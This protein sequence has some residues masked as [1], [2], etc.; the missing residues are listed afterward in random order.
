MAQTKPVKGDVRKN[1]QAHIDLVE[2]AINHEVE[3]IVFPE[4]SLTGYEPTL[5]SSLAVYKEDRQFDDLQGLS[6]DNGITI[7][8]GMPLKIDEGICIGMILFRPDRPRLAYGKKHLH[9]SETEYFVPGYGKPDLLVEKV[10]I[11]LAI[12]YELSVAEHAEKAYSNG[13][14]IYMASVMHEPE[15]VE[16]CDKR[17]KEIAQTYGMLVMSSNF[18]GESDD[19]NYAGQSKVWDRKGRVLAR[20]DERDEGIMI[21]DT[22]TEKVIKR[23][24]WRQL[25]GAG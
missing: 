24:V 10:R 1:I 14:E 2:M 4:L 16:R 6:D 3:L 15:C 5:A 18:V 7:C 9:A 22:E 12:C 11:A 23:R 20:L 21:V 13:A 8:A 19:Y 25:L 17:L